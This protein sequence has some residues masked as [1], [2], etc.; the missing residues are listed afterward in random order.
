[1]S[2]VNFSK[3]CAFDGKS[4]FLELMCNCGGSVSLPRVS[5]RVVDISSHYHT[6]SVGGAHCIVCP[7]AAACL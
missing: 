7:S 4:R 5:L 6:T 3:S 2:V 1:M